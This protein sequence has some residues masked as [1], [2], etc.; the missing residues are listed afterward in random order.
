MQMIQAT[1]KENGRRKKCI[2]ALSGLFNI[3]EETH[4]Q[5]MGEDPSDYF[6]G[7]PVLRAVGA[8]KQ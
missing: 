2:E 7:N 1:W 3:K 6:L 5:D 8:K 4:I